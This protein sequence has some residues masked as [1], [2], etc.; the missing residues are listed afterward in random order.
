[1]TSSL[2]EKLNRL[3]ADHEEKRVV[4]VGTTCTG[5]STLLPSIPNAFDMDD[6]LFPQLSKS[7]TDFVC[8]TPWTE[9]IGRTMVCLAKERVKVKPGS[10]VFGTV[11]LDCDLIIFLV[12]SDELLKERCTSRKVSFCDAKNMQKQLEQEIENSGLAAIDFSVG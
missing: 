7:E 3:L 2:A 6:L 12:I 5:K 4:V 10:P 8:Q 11:I 9:E 1:M